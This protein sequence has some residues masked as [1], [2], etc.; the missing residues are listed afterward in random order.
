[1]PFN[2]KSHQITPAEVGRKPPELNKRKKAELEQ[3]QRLRSSA[4]WQ[5]FRALCIAK[6]PLCFD[7]YHEHGDQA[8]LAEHIHH[9]EPLALRPDLLVTPSNCVPL[10]Q[11]C[12]AR[13]E[14]EERRGRRTAGLFVTWQPS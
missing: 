12:H 10:C 9:I 6:H 13:I 14:G 4:R 5:T 1:M 7:P 11:L 8:E 2:F 3:A